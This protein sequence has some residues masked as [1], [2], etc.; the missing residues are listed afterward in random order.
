MGVAWK[1]GMRV[2]AILSIEPIS[3]NEDFG[4]YVIL[5]ED[6][7]DLQKKVI[8]LLGEV[9]REANQRIHNERRP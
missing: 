6:M 1:P 3:L 9:G 2:K 5:E 4:S 8:E 7:P